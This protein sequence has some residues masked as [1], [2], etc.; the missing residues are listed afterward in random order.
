MT[1]LCVGDNN[2][3]T[4]CYRGHTYQFEEFLLSWEDKLKAT[5]N[6]GHQSTVTVRLQQQVD[7]F[8]VRIT[9]D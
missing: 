3:C 6:E 9:N 1:V 4:L 2:V 7:N 8:R 5:H